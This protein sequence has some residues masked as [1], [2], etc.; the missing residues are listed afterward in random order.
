MSKAALNDSGRHPAAAGHQPAQWNMA[1]AEYQKLRAHSDALPLDH[2]EVDSAVDAYCEAMDRLINE[3]RAPHW[4][5][6]STKLQLARWR[7]D[8]SGYFT[9]YF[10][11]IQAD[12]DRLSGEAA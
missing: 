10:D 8:G 6:V 1:L 4:L 12:I 9:E 3:V 2:P 11:A 7:C 5:A